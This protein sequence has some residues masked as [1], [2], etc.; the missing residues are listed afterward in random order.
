MQQELTA[1]AEIL[2]ASARVCERHGIAAAAD[3]S[4]GVVA[5]ALEVSLSWVQT[6]PGCCPWHSY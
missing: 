1:T 2:L 5:P 6:Q 3:Y 4:V